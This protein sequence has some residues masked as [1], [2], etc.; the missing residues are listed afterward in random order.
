MLT[1][2]ANLVFLVV[3]VLESNIERK[4]GAKLSPKATIEKFDATPTQSLAQLQNSQKD[5]HRKGPVISFPKQSS[6]TFFPASQRL[7]LPNTIGL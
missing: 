5:C 6:F 1:F 3:F 4:T 2:L 7:E